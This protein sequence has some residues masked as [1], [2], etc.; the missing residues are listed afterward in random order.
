MPRSKNVKKRAKAAFKKAA[1]G[2]RQAAPAIL[3]AARAAAVGEA[4]RAFAPQLNAAR[5]LISGRGDYNVT[6]NQLVRSSATIPPRFG[7][8]SIRVRRRELIAPITSSGTAG[9]FKLE[10]FTI[11]PGY[12]ATFPWLSVIAQV[13]ESWRPMGVAFEYVSLSGTAVGSTNTALGQLILAPQYNAY[14]LDPVNKVQLEGFPDAVSVCVDQ[15]ALLGVEC[16]RNL[17]QSDALLIRNTN[18][19]NNATSMAAG[20]FDLGDLFVATNGLQGTTVAVGEL[21]VIYDVELFNPIVPRSI[22]P[23]GASFYS[24]TATNQVTFFDECAQ[25]S[26]DVGLVSS[27]SGATIYFDNLQQGAEYVVILYYTQTSGVGSCSAVC[28]GGMNFVGELRDAPADGITATS[29]MHTFHIAVNASNTTGSMTFTFATT[30]YNNIN[31]DIL[32][33]SPEMVL[34]P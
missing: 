27:L 4:R 25:L 14:G 30:T 19:V 29:R 22:V 20:L 3:R 26:N 16:K 34:I 18:V 9:A 10:K 23:Q 11:N 28:A 13:F 31:L 33:V 15:S 1:G 17:R 21:W 2:V 32:P 7:A 6:S 12:S 5:T 8:T 24:N